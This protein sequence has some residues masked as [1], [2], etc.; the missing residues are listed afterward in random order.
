M[1]KYS[2]TESACDELVTR[3]QQ[4][5]IVPAL[6]V[7]FSI[8]KAYVS[9][10]LTDRGVQKHSLSYVARARNGHTLNEAAFDV[11][12]DDAAYW[13]GFLMA[14]GA[15]WGNKTS[16]ELKT[17]DK[18][19]LEKFRSFMNGS[20]DIHIR[21]SRDSCSYGFKS[22]KVVAR[23]AELGITERKSHTA[24]PP[25]E[26]VNNHH[27]WRGMVDGDGSIGVAQDS[28]TSRL[29]IRLIGSRNVVDAFGTF[30]SRFLGRPV[31]TCPERNI[32]VAGVS[33]I[34]AVRLT[35]LLYDDATTSLDRKAARAVEVKQRSNR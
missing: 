6:V 1:A 5:E 18:K 31:N 30:A 32:F 9:K 34:P 12:T 25:P 27:F 26:L 7:R 16:L 17:G 14:D 15:V 11:L 22:A 28:G 2:L 4:G 24:T 20:Q 3:Y 33:G 8:P 10:I 19:H 21:K 35:A 23:L 13:L 29:R